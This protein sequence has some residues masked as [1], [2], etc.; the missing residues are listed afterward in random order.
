MYLSQLQLKKIRV[1]SIFAQI[2]GLVS[3]INAIIFLKKK[4]I[5]IQVRITVCLKMLT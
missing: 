2:I 1:L 5:G 3:K 4:E